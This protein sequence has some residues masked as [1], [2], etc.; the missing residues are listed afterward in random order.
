[1]QYVVHLLQTN[2][3]SHF[4]LFVLALLNLIIGLIWAAG[5]VAVIV[6]VLNIMTA[7]FMIILIGLGIDFSIHV[8]STFAEMRAKGLSLEKATLAGLEK[9]GKGVSTGALTTSVAF[10]ALMIGEKASDIILGRPAE[11][12]VVPPRRQ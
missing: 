6:P 11:E 8:I 5:I 12:A 4:G 3:L 9:S 10:L 1:M 2:D 7:M